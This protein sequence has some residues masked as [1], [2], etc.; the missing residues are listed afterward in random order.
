MAALAGVHLRVGTIQSDLGD[1][2]EAQSCIQAA[3]GLYDKL[4]KSHP[5]DRAVSPAWRPASSGRA[6]IAR[7]SPSGKSCCKV[8][9]AS[10]GVRRD[11]GRAY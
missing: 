6:T 4:A 8:E 7:R 9:P 2:R 10:P 11:L 1:G 3:R 5:D